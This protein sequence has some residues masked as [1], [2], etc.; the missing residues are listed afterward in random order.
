MNDKLFS[1]IKECEKHYVR[2]TNRTFP[3]SY[4]IESKTITLDKAE[5]EGFDSWATAHYNVAT[6]EHLLKLWE[7]IYSL[8]SEYI[9]FHEFTHMVDTYMY[10]GNDKLKYVQNHGYTEF[11]AS[12]IETLLLLGAQS[13][14]DK[15]SFPMDKKVE[16]VSKQMTIEEFVYEPHKIACNMISRKDFP[17]N[18]EALKV[19][20]GLIFNYYGRRSVCKKYAV[21]FIDNVDNTL[22]SSLIVED[23]VNMYN[24]VLTDFLSDNIISMLDDLYGRMIMALIKKYGLTE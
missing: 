11:H 23:T 8:P 17:A 19:T 18:I 13:V 7:N 10:V 21:D 14:S 16:T 6:K 24:T 9:V 15:I 20:L 22:I 12:Q 4:E 3:I 2:F 1:Y 5:R